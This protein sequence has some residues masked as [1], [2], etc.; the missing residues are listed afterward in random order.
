MEQN[1]TARDKNRIQRLRSGNRSAI[2]EVLQEVRS[3]GNPVIV[4]E[5]LEMLANQEEGEIMDAVFG[6]LNDLKDQESVPVLVEALQDK[7]YE[8]VH[9]RIVAACWQNGLSCE[10]HAMTFANLAL[11][12]SYETALEAFTVLEGC[13]GELNAGDRTRLSRNLKK[14][15]GETDPTKQVLLA[16]LVRMIDSYPT[17]GNS[18]S[19]SG[20][21]TE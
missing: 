17:E 6:L 3:D 5:I 9:A 14:H 16:E 4:R 8:H 21:S 11:K 1:Q 20:S 12:G 10:A 19:A 15:L 18:V 13:I 2:L 7:E